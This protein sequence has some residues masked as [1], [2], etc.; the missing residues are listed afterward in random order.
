MLRS[1]LLWGSENAFL[2]GRLPRYRF[3][4]RAVRRFMPG[5]DLEDAL[6]ESSALS[7]TNRGTLLTLLGE[8]VNEESESTEVVQSYLDALA[9]GL[10]N[11]Q[12]SYPAIDIGSYPYYR[13]GKYGTSIVLRHTDEALLEV[14]SEE[15]AALM[16]SFGDEPRDEV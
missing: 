7:K 3:V 5:E 9:A 4:K 1:V 8:N 16:R 11:I 14:A 6:R 2:A 13:R 10:G 12:D 15:V